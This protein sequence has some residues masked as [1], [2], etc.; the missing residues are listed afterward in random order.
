MD[1]LITH[2][3]CTRVYNS[4]S[5]T[6]MFTNFVILP[7]KQLRELFF[8]QSI[9]FYHKVIQTIMIFMHI[10]RYLCKSLSIINYSYIFL[11]LKHD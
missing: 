1:S 9:Y 11:I 7:L 5:S 2:Q 8:I 3:E 10:L 4:L 6:L